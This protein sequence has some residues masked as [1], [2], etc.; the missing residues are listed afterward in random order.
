MTTVLFENCGK[1]VQ[2]PQKEVNRSKKLGRRQFCSNS[3]GAITINAPRKS[4]V[5]TKDCQHCKK[6]FITKDNQHEATFCSRSCASLG[7]I[8]DLRRSF[9]RKGRVENLDTSKGMKVREAWKYV[10]LEKILQKIPHEFEFKLGKYIFDLQLSSTKML[11][12]FDGAGHRAGSEKLQDTIK[13]HTAKTLGY[14]VIRIPVL[15]N[16]VIPAVSLTGIVA[17][18]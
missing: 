10:D 2:R 9:Y 6:K 11:I 12:E 5:I 8:T 1:E 16:S 14:R 18:D 7:S 15:P 17:F 13:D 3:C 4:K